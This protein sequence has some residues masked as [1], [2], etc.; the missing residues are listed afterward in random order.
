MARRLVD[1]AFALALALSCGDD[2]AGGDEASDDEP[3]STPSSVGDDASG[4][5]L[6]DDGECMQGWG[7]TPSW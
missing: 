7:C 1:S 5:E 4:G 6:A 2:P 3:T